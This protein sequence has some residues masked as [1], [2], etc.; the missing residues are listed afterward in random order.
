ML[1]L[2]Q[3]R[4][5]PTEAAHFDIAHDGEVYRIALRR[6]ATSRRFTL[7]VRAATRDALL[8]MPARSSLRSAREFAER[9]AAWIGTRLSRLPRPI[10]FEPRA[11][12]P[13]RGV[14]HVIAH[15]PGARG[16][17]WLE[18]GARGPLI[19]VAGEEVL[20]RFALE[21]IRDAPHYVAGHR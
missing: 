3:R 4:P 8:T 9:H 21:E 1:R 11:V 16:V 19:C 2:F 18:A 14:D 17:V 5:S 20:A 7:R 12:T 13:L 6:V 15:R 10:A